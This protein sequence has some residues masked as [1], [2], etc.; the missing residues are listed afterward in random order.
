VSAGAVSCF[1]PVNGQLS[2]LSADGDGPSAEAIHVHDQ[3]VAMLNGPDWP[4]VMGRQSIGEGQYFFSMLDE[5]G[6]PR[7]AAAT[8]DALVR[9]NE[10]FPSTGQTTK[11]A[12][13]VAVHRSPICPTEEAFEGLLWR[14]LQL[15]HDNDNS[16]WNPEVSAD[17]AD[18]KFSFSVGSRAFYVIGMHSASSRY[19]RRFPYPALIFNPHDQF[20]A[21]RAASVFDRIKSAIRTR[22]RNLQ[23]HENPMLADHGTI[24]EARQYSGRQVE[25]EWRCPFHPRSE[26]NPV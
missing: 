1:T 16:P 20:E 14:H 4:C 24:S 21:L 12:S 6:D 5:L 15:I 22:D 13:F 3:F 23:G 17:P 19:S 7:C 10:Q 9:F 11:F 18:P 26:D 8:R 25:N 2:P